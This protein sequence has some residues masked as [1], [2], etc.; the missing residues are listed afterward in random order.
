M[1]NIPALIGHKYL[2]PGNPYPNGEPVNNADRVA[3]NHDKFYTELL[4]FAN[5]LSEK[6][7]IEKVHQADRQAIKEFVDNFSED[8]HNFDWWSAVGAAGLASKLTI[9]EKLGRIFYPR[10]SSS[11]SG[12]G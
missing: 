1:P 12:N 5:N 3:A 8:G 7:F 10:K 2:G 9:E 6:E 4:E 11:I